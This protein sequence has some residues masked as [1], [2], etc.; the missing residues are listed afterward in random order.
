[1]V[2]SLIMDLILNGGKLNTLSSLFPLK[3]SK[4]VWVIYE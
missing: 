1:M 3:S 4:F 2:I